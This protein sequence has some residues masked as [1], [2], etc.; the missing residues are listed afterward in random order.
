MILITHD[1]SDIRELGGDVVHLDEGRLADP[2]T[3]SNRA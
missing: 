1:D 2:S 3:F